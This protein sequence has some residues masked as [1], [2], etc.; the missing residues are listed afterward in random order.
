MN[1]TINPAIITQREKIIKLVFSIISI[2]GATV[3]LIIILMAI[4]V[5]NILVEGIEIPFSL[6]IVGAIISTVI[7]VILDR[8][9]WL[10]TKFQ[11][12]KFNYR[13]I[14][15]LIIASAFN[16]ILL[17][18]Y[19]LP[20]EIQNLDLDN[21]ATVNF[22]AFLS[23]LL[24]TG[25]VANLGYFG[26]KNLISIR[27]Q[28]TKFSLFASLSTFLLLISSIGLIYLYNNY[29]IYPPA[30]IIGGNGH[31]EGPWL[32]WHND[33]PNDSICITWLTSQPNSSVVYYGNAPDNLSLK[34]TGPGTYLHQVFLEDLR[35]STMYYYW[36]P[37][38]F[39]QIHKYDVF[40]FTT[41]SNIAHG[42]KFAI[43][44]DMQPSNEIMASKNALVVDGLIDGNFEFVIQLGDQADSGQDLEDWHRVLKNIARIGA[45]TPIQAIIGNHDW[46]AGG[47]S[48]NWGALYSYPYEDPNSGRHF[49]FDYY[50]AHFV[51]IDNFEHYY[52][53][54]QAQLDW[55]SND[56][57]DAKA[58]GQTWV[59]CFFHLSMITTSTSEVYDDLQRTL[60]PIFDARDV[61]AVFYAH[62]HDYQHYE[63]TYG[64]NG[65]WFDQSHDW[66]HKEIQYFCTGG[67]GA[68]LEVAYG[69]YQDKMMQTDVARLWNESASEYQDINFQ[70]TPWNKSRYVTHAGF[71]QNYTHYAD[72]DLG[73]YYYYVP[74]IESY[75]EYC[76]TL[77]LQ[78][79]EQ[80]YHYIE[81][82]I[83]G[84]NCKIS[85]RYPNGE[86]LRGPGDAYPQEWIL[87]K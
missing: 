83:S 67:G 11:K 42:F 39:N 27:I 37:E 49:S 84:P 13:W 18:Y 45:I 26:A 38:N 22:V 6:G 17:I 20:A 48:A 63:Y 28:K 87:T 43:F 86:L 44:G 54:S 2:A 73:K 72:A 82:Q 10:S 14:I 75:N 57:I 12:G 66:D 24:L 23:S 64:D 25:G 51:M 8:N 81:I 47:G 85:A 41:A 59:F 79:A 7:K 5:I 9:E 74:E 52:A 19:I 32:T 61:D 70:Q 36:I 65:L 29:I 60:M 62:D 80:A 15:I 30:A 16:L 40:N 69:V 76:E 50:N 68:N 77:G 3:F 34:A 31:T 35:P 33:R 58:R 46:E 55:I 53:M 4:D 1:E 71:E 21:P 56:I 78:Y